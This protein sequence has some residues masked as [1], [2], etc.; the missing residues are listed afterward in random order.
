M[1]VQS[2]TRPSLLHP[3]QSCYIGAWNVRTMYETCKAA[4]IERYLNKYNIQILGISESRWTG[5][6]ITTTSSRNAIIYSG[7]EEN[8][9]RECVAIV[10]TPTAK[11]RLLE[12]E[13]INER[14]ITARFNGRYAKIIVC[15]KR[16]RGRTERYIL[17]TTTESN[18]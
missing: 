7:R 3:K 9:H 13:P 1:T 6:G 16:Y 8:N 2:T 4:Q 15:Y 10:M 11:K 18:R 14:L 17:L 12:W 5:N